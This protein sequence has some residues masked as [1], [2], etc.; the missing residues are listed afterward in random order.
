LVSE[1]ILPS[2]FTLAA[3]PSAL[4]LVT[5]HH[6]TFTVTATSVGIFSDQLQLS[7][8]NLPAHVTVNFTPAAVA[9]AQGGQAVSS[10]NLDT[11]D[12]IGYL[13][14]ARSQERGWSSHKSL[15]MAAMLPLLV[16]VRRKRLPD[17]VRTIAL[18]FLLVLLMTGAS[19]CSGKYP[20]STA[21]G[22]YA[23]QI[24]AGGVHTGTEHVLIVPLTVTE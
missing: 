9:L 15:A 14:N 10:V 2:D 4:N 23:I 3:T 13:S 8:S 11:D 12:V 22:T 16:A 17:S 5:G 20:A 21:P 6:T 19:G 7:T 1:V 18:V 24:H